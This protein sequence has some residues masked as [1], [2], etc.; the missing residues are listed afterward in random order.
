MGRLLQQRHNLTPKDS[1][2]YR[3]TIY[4]GGRYTLEFATC[5]FDPG[6][7][8]TAW[9][10]PSRTGIFSEQVFRIVGEDEADPSRGSIS[11]VSP[12]ARAMFGKRVGDLAPRRRWRGRNIRHFVKHP[13]GRFL[14]QNNLF[15]G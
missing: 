12:L 5:P 10:G 13:D 15:L 9:P 7:L 8:P 14:G 11:H 6:T 2:S 1:N 3:P 4:C